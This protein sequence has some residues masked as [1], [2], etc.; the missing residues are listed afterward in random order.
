MTP[1]LTIRLVAPDEYADAGRLTAGAYRH[2]YA[3]LNEDYLDSL[4][5]VEGRVA[6][7][8]VWVA[9]E[10]GELVGTVW[11]PR[12]GERL[13]PL[14]AEGEIDF[15]QLAVA[16]SA[17][18]RG[19]GEALTRHVLSLARDRGAQRVVMNSDAEMLG[20]HALYLKLGFHRLPEREHPVEVAP[21]RF[22]DLL[23]FGFDL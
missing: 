3:G 1:T 13:S 18:G 4:A 8:E 17:R 14:A 9:L 19:V 21:G 23:A 11:T 2:S 10:G 22:L 5:D 15:R 12:P 20:A 16:P 7:G 6:Q